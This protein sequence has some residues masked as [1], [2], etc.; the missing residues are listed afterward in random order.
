MEKQLDG[1]ERWGVEAILKESARLLCKHHRLFLPFYLAFYLPISIAGIFPT[2]FL[3]PLHYASFIT[4][5]FTTAQVR[6]LSTA[7][8]NTRDSLN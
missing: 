2:V 7:V 8:H 3:A 5:I 4:S 6:T 1:M